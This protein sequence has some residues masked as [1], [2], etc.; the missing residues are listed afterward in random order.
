MLPWSSLKL[1]ISLDLVS[2][3]LYCFRA[4]VHCCYCLYIFFS[5]NLVRRSE[6]FLATLKRTWRQ[7]PFQSEVKPRPIETRSL[8]SSRASRKLHLFSS[9]FDWFMRLTTSLVIGQRDCFG[10]SFRHSIENHL[11]RWTHFSL[12]MCFLKPII[13]SQKIA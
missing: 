11:I 6:E 9:S 3:K 5:A 4:R 2:T 13:T 10:F 8:R 1:V 12:K 7:F